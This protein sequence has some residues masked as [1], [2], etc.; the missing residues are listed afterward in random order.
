MK[1]THGAVQG[2]DNLKINDTLGLWIKLDFKL[3]LLSTFNLL[4]PGNFSFYL[5]YL[6]LGFLLLVTERFLTDRN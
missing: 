2:H 6:V 4:K 5:S 1:P 3:V